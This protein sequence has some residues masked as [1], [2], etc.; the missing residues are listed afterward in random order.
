MNES[1]QQFHD[2]TTAPMEATG[3]HIPLLKLQNTLDRIARISIGLSWYHHA[4]CQ[5][6]RIICSSCLSVLLIH[7]SIPKTNETENMVRRTVIMASG[8]YYDM[9]GA[10]RPEPI[11]GAQNQFMQR[12]GAT[13]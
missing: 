2:M 1:N 12:G 4:D 8:M 11:G 6:A 10:P 3:G 5:T 7:L 13:R 9:T